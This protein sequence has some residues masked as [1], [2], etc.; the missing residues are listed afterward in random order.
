MT[1]V[2]KTSYVEVAPPCH[3][4]AYKHVEKLLKNYK[5]IL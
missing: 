4:T 1:Y 3:I 5:Y 2:E